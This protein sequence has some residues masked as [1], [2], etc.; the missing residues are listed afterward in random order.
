M[1]VHLG[2]ATT[3]IVADDD[4]WVSHLTF[5]DD[6]HADLPTDVLVFSAGIRPAT[7]SPRAAGL[8]LGER[9][10]IVV[11]ANLRTSAPDVWAIGECALVDGRI[12]G[13]VAPGLRHGPGGRPPAHRRH[14]PTIRRPR[15]PAPT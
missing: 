8:E 13:L 1:H 12:Y 15:S 11:D 6:D 5:A 10:G 14:R 2:H 7:T 9:G 3:E 4:G